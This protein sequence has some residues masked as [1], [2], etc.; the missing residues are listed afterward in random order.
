M[1]DYQKLINSLPSELSTIPNLMLN[2]FPIILELGGD[3]VKAST[4]VHEQK[5]SAEFPK[6]V[7]RCLSG[8]QNLFLV[9][10]GSNAAYEQL[11]ACQKKDKLSLASFRDWHS[12]SLDALKHLSLSWKKEN[13]DLSDAEANNLAIHSCCAFLACGDAGKI[14]RIYNKYSK[15]YGDHDGMLAVAAKHGDLV[16]L[17][18]LP[19]EQ[20]TAFIALAGLNCGKAVLGEYCYP[21]LRNILNGASPLARS[22][23]YLEFMADVSGAAGHVVFNGSLVM[24]ENTYRVFDDLFTALADWDYSSNS[25][26]HFLQKQ[27]EYL[28]PEP[29]LRLALLCK[30]R[31]FKD[32]LSVTKAFEGCNK[33]TQHIL[34]RES[35]VSFT[36]GPALLSNLESDEPLKDFFI[37]LARVLQRARCEGLGNNQIQELC[38]HALTDQFG[39]GKSEHIQDLA[40]SFDGVSVIGTP[41]K[42]V[43]STKR[44]GLKTWHKD[45]I[46]IGCGG[47][48]D[49]VSAALLADWLP[50]L[51]K[52]LKGV[53]STR[54]EFSGSPTPDAPIGTR[55][56]PKAR[57]I[58]DGVFLIEH[59][60]TFKGRGYEV[61]LAKMLDVPLLWVAVPKD[62][63]TLKAR[64]SAAR[65][66]INQNATLVGVDTGGDSICSASY[67][68]GSPDQDF[69][70]L[71]ALHQLDDHALHIVVAPGIDTHPEDL[72]KFVELETTKVQEIDPI[73]VLSSYAKLGIL[74][75]S[76]G[77]YSK[78][79]L[80]HA[81]FQRKA[82][83]NDETIWSELPLPFELI[84]REDNAWDPYVHGHP[85]SSSLVLSPVSKTLE[86]HYGK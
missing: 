3:G 53:I 56:V 25:V 74:E 17:A 6:E 57:E 33:I 5:A 15:G 12:A 63:E 51:K 81:A 11:T 18:S 78:T 14:P 75:P 86:F 22:I 84:D 38:F 9:L 28:L 72:L 16:E 39:K 37:V 30:T 79:A 80:A 71:Q 1:N 65:E 40:F 48:A 68:E 41:V 36:Y 35:N 27:R 55:R 69:R 58:S 60:S 21:E 83:A 23:K 52:R 34:Q 46:A 70:V 59:D 64:L 54:G 10:N 31:N 82:A 66:Y 20:Q 67:N 8:I 77:K 61:D 19:D 32:L 76:S 29:I 49:S 26:W 7:A 13:R 44:G 85:I 62:D 4:E 2:T 24:G 50:N 42:Q 43:A 73:L 47:G 45:F